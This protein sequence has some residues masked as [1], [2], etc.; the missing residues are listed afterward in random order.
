MLSD[1]NAGDDHY[2]SGS[3]SSA[4]NRLQAPLTLQVV[5]DAAEEA[6]GS[7]FHKAVQNCTG[8][9]VWWVLTTHGKYNRCNWIVLLVGWRYCHCGSVSYAF[10]LLWWQPSG[11]QH[12]PA[13]I[14][15]CE[16]GNWISFPFPANR[17][18]CTLFHDNP[19]DTANI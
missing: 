6:G 17:Y 16:V 3:R 4:S 14:P 1:L 8:R 12:V 10:L 18:F 11:W 9:L 2:N 7:L 19:D 5:R 15:P 13:A